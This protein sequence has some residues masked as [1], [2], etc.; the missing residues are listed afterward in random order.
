MNITALTNQDVEGPLV[1][2]QRYAYPNTIEFLAGRTSTGS[3]A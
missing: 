2:W 3:T 1:R